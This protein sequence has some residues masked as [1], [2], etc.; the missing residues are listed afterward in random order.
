MSVISVG[1]A[2]SR[3]YDDKQPFFMA[4]SHSHEEFDVK[5]TTLNHRFKVRFRVD[6]NPKALNP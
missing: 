1:A 5:L 4:G 3:D 6:V 2:S